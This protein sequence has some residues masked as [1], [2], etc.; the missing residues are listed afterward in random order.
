M[1][2]T[3]PDYSKVPP[4]KCDYIS[5]K[6]ENDLFVKLKS[7]NVP[8]YALT[9]RYTFHNFIHWDGLAVGFLKPEPNNDPFMPLVSFL[10]PF[11]KIWKE[12]NR[13]QFS[14]EELAMIDNKLGLIVPSDEEIEK[15]VEILAKE[16]TAPDK[17]TPDW[18]KA[19]I[20]RGMIRMREQIIKLNS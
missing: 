4:M 20:R 12:W 17:E 11:E 13:S 2:P 10:A 16:S 5:R 15:E 1:T 6:E 18:M 9:Q 7:M 3:K 14:K 8:K 19:D